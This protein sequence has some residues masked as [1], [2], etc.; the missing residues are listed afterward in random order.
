MSSCREID[1]LLTPYIDGE[2]TA[3]ERTMVGAHLTGCP[4]CRHRVEAEQAA[5]EAVRA[6]VSRPCAPEH[7]RKRCRKTATP[8]GRLTSTYSSSTLS[9]F[10]VV[11]VVAGGVSVYGLT[12]LSPSLLAAQ[13]ALDHVK[14]FSIHESTTPLDVTTAEHQLAEQYGWELPVPVAPASDGLQLVGVRRCFC[15]EG[16]AIHLMYRHRG[17]PLSLY[18]IPN[19]A[20]A[21]V[22]TEV[23][24]HDALM[25]S[26][27]NTTFVLLGKE[28]PGELRQ[29]AADLK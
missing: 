27:Q 17:D 20:R 14:C 10:A 13:L 25:W 9:M 29:L 22:S 3:A 24:G 23:F 6:R 4:P 1:P 12:R 15:G 18:L 8:L 5:R 2:T 28:T 11:I 21:S 16:P 19:D 7:L 26:N